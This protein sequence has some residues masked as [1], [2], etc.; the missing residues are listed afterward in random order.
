MEMRSD[1]IP[2]GAPPA[3]PRAPRV[4]MIP[5]FTL[6]SGAVLRDVRQAYFLDGELSPARD[7][8]VVV[9]HSL[10]ASPDAMG[11]WW[12]DVIGP[13]KALDTDR[14]A[15]VCANLLG[16]CFGTTGP[17]SSSL[18]PFPSV[19]LRDMV[20]LVRR[21][22]DHLGVR[23]VRL[24]TGGSLGGM[25]ALEWAATYP[26]RT[27]ST[28]AFAAPAALSAYSLGWNHLQRRAIQVAG[29]QGMEIARMAGMMV[30][31]TPEEFAERFGRETDEQGRFR[32]WTYLEHH[33]RRLTERF[34]TASY[35][36]MLDAIAGHDV[37]RG[38][39]GIAAALG[40]SR[41]RVIGV[42]IPSDRIY[43]DAEI[44]EWAREAGCE[45]RQL[46]S[47]HG[48]D[49]FLL[50]PEQVGAILR[51]ALDQDAPDR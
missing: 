10:S 26:E 2:G 14:F 51:D 38:R 23:R 29:A 4:Q 18:R 17:A 27:A 16:S 1:S 34:D 36:V 11:E 25:L 5:E 20:R 33:G 41:G 45:H 9:F 31:R 46:L 48:H 39:G 3:A 13:G 7:N 12:S 44:R 35:L 28:V 43:L 15:V 6:E 42:G 24:A 19:S 50:E 40:A 30:Y 8:L 49:A 32:M 37:G 22:V 47:S 21:L